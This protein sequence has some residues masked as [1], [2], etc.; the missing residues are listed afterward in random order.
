MNKLKQ[1]IKWKDVSIFKKVGLGSGIVIL[2]LMG[3][4]SQSVFGISGILSDSKDV[5]YGNK[6]D[7]IFAQQE[8]DHLNWIN[9]ISKLLNG[10]DPQKLDI[11]TDHRTC[12]LGNW[13]YSDA[14]LKAEQVVPQLAPLLKRIE[15]PHRKMHGS[16]GTI[17]ETLKPGHDGQG[18]VQAVMAGFKGFFDCSG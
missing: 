8:V 17:K 1:Y 2:F 16:A 15:A 18:D 6:L 11:N 13:L 7:G 4:S 5:I 14:R 10:E 9:R 3:I 12:S